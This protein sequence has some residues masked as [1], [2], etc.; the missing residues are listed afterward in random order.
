MSSVLE[1]RDLYTAAFDRLSGA[2]S[3]PAW[4]TTLRREAMDRFTALGFPTTRDEA[5]RF[6]SVAPI[7]NRPFGPPAAAPVEAP[8]L[9]RAIVLD[10]ALAT[11]VFVN[12]RYAPASSDVTNVPRGVEIGSLAAQIERDPA[13]VEP[14]LARHAT[15]DDRTFTALN[16]ALWQDGAFVRL[17]AGVSLDGPVQLIFVSVPGSDPFATHPR[18]LILAGPGSR[19]RFVERYVSAGEGS[20]FTNAVAEVVL[21]DGATVDHYRVVQ[22]SLAAYHVSSLHV[23][24]ARAT[25]FAS[26]AIT[27]GGALVRHE[28]IA[29]LGGEGG[30]CTLNG[31]Y[32]VDGERL[33]DNHTTIDHA[34]P[35]CSSHEMYKG[36]LAGRGRGVFN[37]KIIVRQDAQKTD[38]KQT[39][40]ALL[41]SETSQINTTPQLEIFA[42]DVRCTHG[43]T[44]G[45]LDADQLFYLQARGIG[46]DRA[47]HMLI[48]AF[49]SEVL[50]RVQ[51][52]T[53]RTSL[54]AALQRQLP[55]GDA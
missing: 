3:A 55:G 6:T 15:L 52:P 30:E 1:A 11:L 42:D 50:A 12:G 47:R 41:L 5:W 34:Q 20:H 48:H 33:V 36:V 13:T 23:H 29:V 17:P 39:N 35:H 18:V 21:S 4:L 8:P 25:N 16:T 43:A 46:R 27:L 26:H 31:L 19:S 10:D 44:V 22:E 40:K 7:A 32:L 53:L 24:L 54:E 9:D 14:H 49:A 45:Q 2:A 51:I 37:G 38:A 28:A